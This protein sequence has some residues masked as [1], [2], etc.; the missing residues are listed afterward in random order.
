M[1]QIVLGEAQQLRES[2]PDLALIDHL[3]KT[4]L[5]IPE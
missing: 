2:L 5:I 3:R 4:D 1:C